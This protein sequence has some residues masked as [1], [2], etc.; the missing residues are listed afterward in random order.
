VAEIV[1]VFPVPVTT[2]GASTSPQFF[3][4]DVVSEEAESHSSLDE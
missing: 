3:F 2:N 1:T 4:V